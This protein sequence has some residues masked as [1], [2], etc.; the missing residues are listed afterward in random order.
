[1]AVMEKKRRKPATG[2]PWP[3][4][5]KA[6]RIHLDTPDKPASQEEVAARINAPLGT[7]RN[8]E[9]G[10]RVPNAMIVRLLELTFP[11]FF[12]NKP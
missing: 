6:L 10:R 5:L 12:G 11:E 1:M 3:E 4:R 7:W 9:Q 8:W 2:N